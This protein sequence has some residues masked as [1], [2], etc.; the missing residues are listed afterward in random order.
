MANNGTPGNPDYAGYTFE[1][2]V[3]IKDGFRR[4]KELSIIGG[5]VLYAVNI[6][7]AYVDAKFFRFDIGDNL[8]LQVRPS[9]KNQWAYTTYKPAPALTF[10]LSL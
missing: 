7:D 5:V 2:L 8:S 6:I 4:N 9:V 10:K 3:K 1:G